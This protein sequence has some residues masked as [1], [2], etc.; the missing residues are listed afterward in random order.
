MRFLVDESLSA[1]VAALLADAGHDAIH[2]GDLQL[3]GATDAQ[4]LGAAAQRE[5]VLVSADTDFGE[6]LALGRHPGPSVIIFRRAPHRPEQ[7]CPLL[8][9]YLPDVEDSL[10]AGAVVIVTRERVRIRQLP[11]GPV[12]ESEVLGD[13][14]PEDPR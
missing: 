7:Q 4:V 5:R 8:L 6:L 10:L 1:S 13:P 11:I 12:G 14:E 2:V 9:A 3:L